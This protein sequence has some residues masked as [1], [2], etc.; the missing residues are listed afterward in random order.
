LEDFVF[1]RS[2]PALNNVELY[3][4]SAIPGISENMQV[5]TNKMGRQMQ[6]MKYY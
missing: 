2:Q 6:I 3:G 5:M 4:N 1:C